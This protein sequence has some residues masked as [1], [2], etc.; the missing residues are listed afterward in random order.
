MRAHSSLV[1][2]VGSADRQGRSSAHVLTDRAPV[3][4]LICV[5]RL[6]L[7]AY[8]TIIYNGAPKATRMTGP[9]PKRKSEHH[10]I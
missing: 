9:T 7:Q 3:Q 6:R 1:V 4:L 8:I 5:S 2:S 10:V